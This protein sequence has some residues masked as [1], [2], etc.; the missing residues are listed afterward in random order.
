MTA[1]L[2]ASA[3]GAIPALAAAAKPANDAVSM[4]DSFT[5]PAGAAC[6]FAV[7]VDVHANGERYKL[8]FDQDGNPTRGRLNGRLV[9][10]M[11][12][13]ET[14]A[15]VVLKVSGPGHDT[16]N[17]D[18]SI[19]TRY[20]GRGVP[21]FDGVFILSVG[22]HDYEVSDS[23]DLLEQGPASGQSHDICDMLS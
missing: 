12:N 3:L 4:P 7:R 23:W 17:A 19:S 2:A 11:T 10:G 18:G 9:L 13:V 5:L 16:F 14:N 8:W 6:D 15:A 1:V 21:L 20:T 22:R